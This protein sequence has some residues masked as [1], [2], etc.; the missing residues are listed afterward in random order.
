M[1]NDWGGAAS[2]AA[3]GAITGASLGGPPGALFGGVIGGVAGLFSGKNKK[4]KRSTMD[5][6]QQ[7]LNKEQFQGLHGEGPFADLYNYDPE[8]ANDVFDKTVANPAY[9]KYKE[10]LAPGITGQFRSNGLQTSSYAGDALS[11][12]A[13]D[14]Q[15]NLDAQRSKYLYG[16][17]QDV[18]NRKSNAI[19]NQQNRTNFDYDTAPEGGFDID[20]I[21]SSI[22]PEMVDQTKNYFNK[23]QGVQAQSTGVAGTSPTPQPGR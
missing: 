3:S 6:R 1:A 11:K 12:V 18:K 4:K 15:E 17:E 10:E 8:K 21:L 22:T 23:K 14:I 7:K 9:R 19:E 16:Q 2:G 5:K 13:R 20:S